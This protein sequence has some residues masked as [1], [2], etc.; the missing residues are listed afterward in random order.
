M[1]TSRHRSYKPSGRL[2]TELRRFFGTC[3][4]GRSLA[5]AI[6]RQ[7]AFR[8]RKER[9]VQALKE[10]LNST[11]AKMKNIETD[12]ER[13]QRENQRLATQNEI[14]RATSQPQSQPP[15]P[16]V[17]PP[18]RE[19]SPIP[20]PQRYSPSSAF[21]ANLMSGI[22]QDHPPHQPDSAP[23]QSGRVTRDHRLDISATSGQR[24]LSMSA[25][26]DVVQEHELFKRGQLNIHE[27]CEKMKGF[28]TCN[29]HGPA[30]PEDALLEAIED[31]VGGSG[32]DLL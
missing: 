4:W 12:F 26:W 16:R 13:L 3:S 21:Q 29:G 32:D 1:R 25:A 30:F 9:H 10:Q 24:L 18:D 23:P 20:G 2:K 5:D 14:L 31:S 15:P 28:S 17:P 22:P 7:R 6:D 11:T 27:L 8:E 19:I